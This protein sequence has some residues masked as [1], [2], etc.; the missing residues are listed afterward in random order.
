MSTTTWTRRGLLRAGSALLASAAL[1]RAHAAPPP[2]VATDPRVEWLS[3]LARAAGHPEYAGG[4]AAWTTPLDARLRPVRTHPAVTRLRNARARSGVSYDALPSLALHLTGEIG[5]FTLRD[6]LSPWPARLD[7]RWQGVDVAAFL[8]EANAAATKA[9]FAALWAE[10]A[11][12]RARA[13][14]AARPV[15]EAFDLAWFEAWFG[16]PTPGTVAVVPALGTAPNNYGTSRAGIQPELAAVLGVV[17][18]DGA[19]HVDADVLVHEV[20]HSFVNPIVEEQARLLEPPGQRLYQAVKV[21]MDAKAYGAWDTVVAESVLRAVGVRYALAHGGPSAARSA[22]AAE[23]AAGFPWVLVLADALARYEAD[24]ARYPTFG[25]FAVELAAV[26]TVIAAEEAARADNRPTVVSITP[27][28]GAADVDPATPALV[29]EFDR[30]MRDQSWSVVGS[31]DELPQS[32]GPRYEAGGTRFVLPW[33]L[34]PGRSY[35]LSLN[36]GRFQGFQSAAGVPLEPV[37]VEFHTR[38]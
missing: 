34:A 12:L 38:R 1:G 18:R 9:G 36:G 8:R 7:A 33:T 30:P 25:D 14:A 5:A 37:A 10:Q 23:V 21:R 4:L 32:S 24:R 19:L 35:R 20:G 3:A 31:P 13:E 26:L 15:V 29:V 22:T 6:A 28:P 16:F 11:P 17:E 2:T 27:R